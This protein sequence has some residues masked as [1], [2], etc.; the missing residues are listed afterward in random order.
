MV[1]STLLDDAATT[2]PGEYA[3]KPTSITPGQSEVSL[4]VWEDNGVRTGIW[5][6]TPGIFTGTRD[7]YN[8]ICQILTGKAT[9]TEK[10]GTSFDIGPGSLFVT[11]AGWEG[12]WTVHETMRKMWVVQELS[13][14][15]QD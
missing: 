9:I 1:K 15:A 13:A 8:E 7:G 10:D 14:P 6:V 4:K 12:T 3:T 2:N 11:P 5:E